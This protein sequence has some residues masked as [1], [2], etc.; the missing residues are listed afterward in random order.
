[1]FEQSGDLPV[2]HLTFFGGET[3]LNFKVL[4]K[5]ARV[6]AR[7][8]EGAGE[9]C[10]LLADDQR[11]AASRRSDRLAGREPRSGVTVSIDGPKEMQDRFRV[12][13][14]G[15]G[16]Y[17][18]AMPKI[19]RLLERHRSKTDR[20]P[21]DAHP[22]D[23][24][25]HPD[26]STI[27]ATKSAS[28]RSASLPVTTANG[29]GYAI[30]DTGFDHMLGQ[31][32]ELAQ[33]FLEFAVE[34]RHHG[35][36]NVKDTI[37]EIHKGV[38]KAFPC[39]AGLGLMGVATDGEVALCHRFA[40]LGRSQHRVGGHGGLDRQRQFEFLGHGT[41]WRTRRTAIPAGR[42]RY[43]RGAAIMRRMCGMGILAKANLHYCDWI[44]SW[45]DTCLKV[46]GE[47][48]VKNPGYL[49]Q[50]GS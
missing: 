24:E 32:E 41:T 25:C 42:G 28:G 35:F 15:M 22:P 9:G 2:A 16:S 36:S 45:T 39:G 18:Y 4:K 5:T 43:A 38:S 34:D 10:R 48:A 12:F 50:F 33:E 27:C 44:R 7:A 29:R 13:K 46:Y 3:L 40:G 23:P 6:C 21:R 11:H 1:M 17:D 49:E 8:G 30:E 26:F 31:F 14:N 19:R 37:E 20:G 47:I